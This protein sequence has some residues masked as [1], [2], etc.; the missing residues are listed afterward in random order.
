MRLKQAQFRLGSVYV[1][2]L[3]SLYI[4]ALRKRY[5]AQPWAGIFHCKHSEPGQVL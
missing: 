4:G 3:S 1:Q 2:Y 5:L